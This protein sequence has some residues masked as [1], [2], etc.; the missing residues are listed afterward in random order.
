MPDEPLELYKYMSLSDE[1]RK[2]RVKELF[3]EY[4]VWFSKPTEFNDP[5]EFHF[6][7]SFE[8]TLTE[9]IE[10]YAKILQKRQKLTES[11]A[12][13]EASSVF[14]GLG[15]SGIEKWEKEHLKLFIE[16]QF[17]QIG[18]FSLTKSNND[19]LM[20]S[21]YA[22]EH[23]GICIELS[24]KFNNKE[25]LDFWAN[26]FEVKYPEKNNLPEVNFYQ[27]RKNPIK[28]VENCMLTKAKHWD[29]EAE[30]RAINTEGPGLKKLPEG[31]ITSV[32]LG[33]CIEPKN[34]E[35]MVNLASDYPSPVKI[36]QAHRKPCYYELEFQQL[37][38]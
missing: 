29:Y 31:I 22:N 7:P 17:N 12:K 11:L 18:I 33:C 28:N 10:V 35:F 5:F 6:T 20:W 2:N 37:I 15:D 21:H 16:R 26:I 25:H 4:E 9:K 14:L 13:A 30:W 19:I 24:P 27:F 1:I 3:Q 23:K 32:L 36:F 8:A 38:Q 34:R